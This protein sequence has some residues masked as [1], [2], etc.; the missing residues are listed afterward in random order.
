MQRMAKKPA[1]SKKK[2]AG[3]EIKHGG[4]WKQTRRAL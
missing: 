1:G 2:A 3:F 4:L